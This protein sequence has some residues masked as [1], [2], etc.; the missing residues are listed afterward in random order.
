MVARILLMWLLRHSEYLLACCCVAARVFW[1]VGRCSVI[2]WPL[3]M[4]Q[5]LHL[6]IVHQANFLSLSVY[7]HTVL[8][9]LFTRS[10][11]HALFTI[12]CIKVCVLISQDT[13]IIQVTVD[14][15]VPSVY[16][17]V[18]LTLDLLYS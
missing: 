4:S 10:H 9:S 12:V 15:Q 1:V 17:V 18:P 7:L 6:Y 5:V 3:D 8:M 13:I 14:L 16:Q 11:R 2:F